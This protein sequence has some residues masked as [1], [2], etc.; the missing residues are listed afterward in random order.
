MFGGIYEGRRVLVTGHS[1]FKGSW[2]SAWLLRLGA[3]VC[4][5]SL[6]P[7]YE[8]NHFSLLDLDLESEWSNILESGEVRSIFAD[9]QPEIVFHL[10]AQALVRPSYEEPGLTFAT[11]VM[12]TVNVLESCRETSSVRAV[13]I[14]TSD[15]CYENRE[16]VW[17]YRENDP[18]GGFDPYSASKGC[19]ELVT[20]AYRRSFFAPETFGKTHSPA[21]GPEM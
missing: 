2:L 13:V 12:G 10:A 5:I 17:G 20:A 11:N 14:V 19:A 7:G 1:G 3:R 6:R 16:W 21:P 15:K 4:G 18:M 8:P 9:F